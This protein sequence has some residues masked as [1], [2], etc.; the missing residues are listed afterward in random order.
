MDGAAFITSNTTYN[1]LLQLINLNTKEPFLTIME[2]QTQAQVPADFCEITYFAII[3][4]NSFPS[5]SFLN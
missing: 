2:V 4:N 1:L 3:A 5:F